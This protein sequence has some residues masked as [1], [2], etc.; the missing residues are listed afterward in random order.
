MTSDPEAYAEGEKE[1]QD[2][3]EEIDRVQAQYSR[4]RRGSTKRAH[5]PAGGGPGNYWMM[6]RR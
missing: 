1:I 3:N 4:S 6:I 5:S 2:D